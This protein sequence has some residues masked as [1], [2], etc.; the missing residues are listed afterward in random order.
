MAN[1]M[2]EPQFIQG[3][4]NIERAIIRGVRDGGG[5]IDASSFQWHRGKVLI[6]PP[7]V[8]ELKIT[9]RDINVDML[10]SYEEIEDAWQKIDDKSDLYL[11]ID[12]AID[13]LLGR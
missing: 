7:M 10:L 6:P 8:V 3:V 12:E 1:I 5:N 9:F 13:M 11:R 2:N 4:Q